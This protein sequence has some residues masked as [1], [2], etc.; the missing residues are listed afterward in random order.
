MRLIFLFLLTLAALPAQATLEIS[1]D[2]GSVA[3][4]PIAVVPFA[5]GTGLPTD[6]AQVVEADLVRSGLY[7][8]L[9]RT[10][11]L[12]TPSTPEAVDYRNWRSTARDYLIVGSAN[13]LPS[14]QIASRFYLLD[15]VRQSGLLAFE[16]PP[17]PESR[18]R[19]V[20]HQM[21]D[22]IIE[23]LT[24]TP[25]VFSTQIAYITSTGYG[26]S[27][28][29][30]LIIADADGY[31]PITVV[32]SR[33][34]LLSP[35]WSPDG[36]TLAY[37]G[38]DQVHSAIWL[39]T[40]ATGDRRKLVAEKGINGA[41]SFSP[42]GRKL[43]VTLS[44]ETNADIYE[45]DLASNARTRL[46]NSKAID[47][48]GSYSPDGSK[49]AFLSDRGGS[50]QVYL[51]DRDGSNQRRVTFQGKQNQRPR[52]SP[53]GK[54]LALVNSDRGRFTIATVNLDGS[55]LQ[56]LSSGPGDESPSYAPNGALIIYASAGKAGAELGIT[57]AD[58]RVHQRLRQVGEVHEP[59]WGPFNKTEEAPSSAA[60][61]AATPVGAP[62]FTPVLN[63]PRSH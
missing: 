54:K 3:A 19:D 53:D 49:I 61:P 13:R 44:F 23:K 62:K 41:P 9:P 20:A 35:A 34:P 48:E 25:G 17:V 8:A 27:R 12:E 24:G 32:A 22:L 40:L 43:L 45:I 10:D 7:S 2:G 15:V 46:T 31:N 26:F 47:T 38:F 50:A 11:M 42:D 63:I 6:L 28:K 37:V 55:G 29:N 14:G 58:G 21:A 39:Y 33:E 4:Q 18:L 1:I 60:M 52:F 5:G 16:M 57:T 59:A 51:M 36:K 56:K 30:E